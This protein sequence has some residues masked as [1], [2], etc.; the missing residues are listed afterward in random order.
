[1]IYVYKET[2]AKQLLNA[3]KALIF[4]A[5]FVLIG[6]IILP[7]F[8]YR[9][10]LVIVCFVVGLLLENNYVIFVSENNQS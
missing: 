7:I 8:V 6:V 4:R 2:I 1:M 10:C 5:L 9:L 3:N